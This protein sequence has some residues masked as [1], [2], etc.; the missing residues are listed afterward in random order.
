MRQMVFRTLVFTHRWLGVVLGLLML[1]WC[2]SGF[3]MMYVP[4]PEPGRE[5]VQQALRP[6][7]NVRCCVLPDE[8]A[9]A[10]SIPVA[11][12]RLQMLGGRPL[13]WLNFGYGR[14]ALFGLDDGA[15]VTLDE[16]QAVNVAR[17]YAQAQGMAAMAPQAD[18][19]EQDQW[20]V[21]PSYGA[22]RPLHRVRLNDSADTVVY[23]SGADGGVVQVTDRPQRFWN[24]LGAVPHWLYFEKLRQNQMWWD[25]TVVWSSAAGCLLTVFG[26]WL[27]IWQLQQ[28]RSG[29]W[30]SPYRG[31]RWWHHVPGLVFGV[32]VFT[33]ILSGLFSMQPWGLLETDSGADAAQLRGEP[34][35]WEA[36]RTVLQTMP[37][38]Q[39]PANTVSIDAAFFGGRVFA[40]AT[41]RNG[42]RQRFDAGWTPMALQQTELQQAGRILDMR[43]T[44]SGEPV[45]DAAAARQSS[46]TWTWQTA[47]D[48][49]YYSHGH[50]RVALPV[51]KV[52]SGPVRYYLDAVSGALLRKVD[53]DA[54]AYRWLHY[55]LHRLDFPLLRER[56]L[57]DMVMW[58]LLMGATLV[59]A[60]GA[61]M[62]AKHLMRT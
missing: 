52:V 16:T 5:A 17:Q 44:A 26:L 58:L 14:G 11:G 59:C 20:T 43:A 12:Y 33:W 8:Q 46:A 57:W 51:V 60:T 10:G 30:R 38:A 49:Y 21:Y 25:R 2:L 3:V 45:P 28:A 7:N 24:W 36:V 31:V 50:E 23:V 13:L 19:I 42:Q 34:P 56:P 54:R 6:L 18:V 61:Y 27:G 37:Q 40:V 32:L 48:F 22:H 29:G 4:Y 39:L 1:L 53:G 41:T 55:G 15:P 47:E 62:G 9:V 35:N